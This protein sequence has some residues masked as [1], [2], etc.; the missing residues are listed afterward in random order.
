MKMKNDCLILSLKIE[1]G[2][3]VYNF[4]KK[5]RGFLLLKDHFLRD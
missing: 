1:K 5:N 2:K 4:M 3:N